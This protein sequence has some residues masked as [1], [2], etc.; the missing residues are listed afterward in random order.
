MG[1]LI[2]N[3]NLVTPEKAESLMSLCP[4]GAMTYALLI[5]VG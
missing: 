4:F 3:Q 1:K 2:I 5:F